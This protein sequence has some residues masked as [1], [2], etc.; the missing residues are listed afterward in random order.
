MIKKRLLASLLICTMSLF[1]SLSAASAALAGPLMNAQALTHNPYIAAAA[2]LSDKD[3][4]A[5]LK[6]EVMPQ[7][8][9]ILTPEQIEIFET[10]ISDGTS[11]RKTFKSLGLMPEQKAEIKTLLK[12]LPKKDAFASLTPMQKKKL[13]LEK[14]EAFMPTSD[15]IID[16]INAKMEVGEG[17]LP[18][19][20]EDKIEAGIKARDAYRPSTESIMD[21]VQAGLESARENIA[22]D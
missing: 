9:A 2:V 20:V 4:L 19:G 10:E 12:T 1:I 16:K 11:F 21:K 15:E 6:T 17:T 8:E 22:G 3:A 5:Q 7:L 18:E 14:K 13:F